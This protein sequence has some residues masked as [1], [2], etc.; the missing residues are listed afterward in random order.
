M[1]GSSDD[2]KL[3]GIELA[4]FRNYEQVTLPALGMLNLFIGPNAMGKTSII[5]AIQLMTSY[6]S[7]RTAK[8]VE[9]VRW[10]CSASCVRARIEGAGRIIDEQMVIDG[11]K[12]SYLLNG[13]TRTA[14]ALRGLLPSV[15][16]TPDN[17]A[18]AKGANTLRLQAV[19]D[20]GVQLS[21]GFSQ[22]KADYTRL[23]KQK[24]Q[25][26]KDEAPDHLIDTID[27]VLVKV[28]SQY[29]VHRQLVCQKM[30]TAFAEQYR[31]ISGG[32]EEVDLAYLYSW[33]KDK[34]GIWTSETCDKEE[35]KEQLSQAL[36]RKR[37]EE[38]ARR[39]AV[40][41]AHADR[42]SFILDRHDAV[43]FASQ[44]QQRSVVLAF[45]L[46]ELDVL[47]QE[48]DTR[49]LLLL[50]DVM[51][52]LDEHRREYFMACIDRNTQ[53]FITTA[54]EHY[55]SRDELNQA[56]VFHLPFEGPIVHG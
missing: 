21:K 47:K 8:V 9:A 15:V 17:L 2:L 27:D 46:A 13:K 5:E 23:V 16:F 40:A 53:T 32:S 36:A 12:R 49:P 1:P 14:A 6:K 48:G 20:I 19:D 4:N 50:D 35:L 29:T 39:K 7:F 25:A 3:A 11:G 33:D 42:V 31:N 52:E 45:K 55:F 28:S 54:H 37:P 38:R 26:L 10:G 18:L 44:G 51:S 34:Q 41:G 24:N 56:C 43:A 30:R 22:V